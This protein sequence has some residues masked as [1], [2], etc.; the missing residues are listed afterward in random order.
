MKKIFS[1]LLISTVIIFVTST[2]EIYGG[3][4]DQAVL[5]KLDLHQSAD[6]LKA[7]I[8]VSGEFG[9]QHFELK[10]PSRLV[11]EISPVGEIHAEAS[12]DINAFGVKAV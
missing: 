12:Y 1:L 8:G 7:V 6:F 4:E 9:Y 11:V 3:Q 2:S 10:D 5:E